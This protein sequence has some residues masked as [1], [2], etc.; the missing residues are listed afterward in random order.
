MQYRKFGRLDW[1]VSALGFGAMRLPCLEDGEIDEPHATRMVRYAIDHGVNYVDTAYG[2]HD[3][4]SE[5]FLGRALADGYRDKVRLATKLPV[6]LVETAADFDR[7]LGEQLARLRTDR[8]DFYLLHSLSG[9]SWRKVRDLGVLA[10][11]ERMIREG[12]IGYLGFSFHDEAA[13]FPEIVDAYDW[14]FCQ[15]QYNYMDQ[16]NQAGR[17]G[18]RYAAAKGLAVVIMEPLLGGKLAD[19]PP[20]IRRL[21]ERAPVKRSPVEWALH[22]LWHQPEISTVLSG[23]SDMAQVEQNVAAADAARAGSMTAEELALVEEVR[24]AYEGLMP[25]P[26]TKCRY[27]LP[28]PHGVDIPRN[29]EAYNN[30]AYGSDEFARSAYPWIPEEERAGACKQCR[31]CEEI[32]PQRIPIAEWLAKIH[33]ALG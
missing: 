31:K 29:F 20:A 26:C 10:W 1:Q 28:C 5:K 9:K 16:N 32:C 33:E 14:T 3:G 15:I 13:A 7:L 18:L 8:I 12:K 23:M 6:W 4:Q 17:E 24:A 19:P 27:C 11:A 2:Y 22:W 25:I 30:K 21:W